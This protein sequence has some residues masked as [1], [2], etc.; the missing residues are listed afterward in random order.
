MMNLSGWW[1]DFHK[2]SLPRWP[3]NK[4]ILAYIFVGGFVLGFDDF[5]IFRQFLPVDPARQA[6][7]MFLAL[8][9]AAIA[10]YVNVLAQKAY[11]LYKGLQVNVSYSPWKIAAGLFIGVFSA[12]LIP[13]IFVPDMNAK[14]LKYQRAG[15]FRHGINLSEYG[16]MGFAGM[17]ANLVIAILFLMIFGLSFPLTNAII[18]AMVFTSLANIIPIPLSGGFYTMYH[19]PIYWALLTGVGVLGVM[20]LFS[21]LWYAVMMGL[22]VSIAMWFIC[23]TQVEN[24]F[25]V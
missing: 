12:G 19:N 22:G 14:I 9:G 25:D 6:F 1:H 21:P 20:L 4:I 11:A 5:N 24:F 8:I 2:Y 18:V 13:L 3:E 17:A 23:A 15:R 7:A 16:K 10:V